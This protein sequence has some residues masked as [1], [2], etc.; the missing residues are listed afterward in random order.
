MVSFYMN[1]FNISFLVAIVYVILTNDIVYYSD[2]EGNKNKSFDQTVEQF[3][4]MMISLSV[5]LFVFLSVVIFIVFNTQVVQVQVGYGMC[6]LT[7]ICVLAVLVGF[8]FSR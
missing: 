7:T 8:A 6:V 5:T 1:P 3:T 2:D 4:Q